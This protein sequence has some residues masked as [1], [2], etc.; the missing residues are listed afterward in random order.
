[1]HKTIN[2]EQTKILLFMWKP[3]R[4]IANICI[5]KDLFLCERFCGFVRRTTRNRKK[6]FHAWPVKPLTSS[7]LIH[8]KFLDKL[9]FNWL[10]QFQVSQLFPKRINGKSSNGFRKFRS[11]PDWLIDFPATY[12]TNWLSLNNKKIMLNHN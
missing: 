11:V 9:P 1:M 2:L 4:V 6:N 8:R 5:Y 12:C 10:F 7:F 3:Q